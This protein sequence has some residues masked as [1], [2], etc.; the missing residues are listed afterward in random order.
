MHIQ[1]FFA[2]STQYTCMLNDLLLTQTGLRFTT[3]ATHNFRRLKSTIIM[4]EFCVTLI[5]LKNFIANTTR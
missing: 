4:W 2:V 3:D 1:T 5:R